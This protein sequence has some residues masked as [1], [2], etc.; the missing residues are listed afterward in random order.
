MHLSIQRCFESTN[1][2]IIKYII[3]RN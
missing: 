1:Q 2:H 3:K